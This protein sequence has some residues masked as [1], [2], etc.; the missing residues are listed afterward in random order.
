MPEI[1]INFLTY[2]GS[3]CEYIFFLKKIYASYEM[4]YYRASDDTRSG[5]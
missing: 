5:A 1:Y 4:F 3:F 2:F